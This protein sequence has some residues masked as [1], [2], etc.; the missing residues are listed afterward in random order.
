MFFW[1]YFLLPVVS[2]LVVH[3]PTLPNSV[4]PHVGS[5]DA[6]TEHPVHNVPLVLADPLDSCS[7]FQNIKSISG[8]VV[9]TERGNCSFQSKIAHAQASRNVVVFLRMT[10][11]FYRNMAQWV[12]LY[13][14][15]CI[16]HAGKYQCL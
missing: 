16:H 9:L 5:T 11:V 8:K 15:M 7:A 10:R 13:S 2:A 4:Y 3:S 12:L 14:T 6:E 1:S